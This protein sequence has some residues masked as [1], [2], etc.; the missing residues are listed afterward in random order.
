[1]ITTKLVSGFETKFIF[2][3]GF[4][5]TKIKSAKAPSSTTPSFPG[6]GLRGQE[7]A[8]N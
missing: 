8:S 3:I 4:P 5:F 1:M 7:S 2:S 6:Y